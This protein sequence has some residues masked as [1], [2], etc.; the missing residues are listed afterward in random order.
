M[1]TVCQ[2]NTTISE[3]NFTYMCPSFHQQNLTFSVVDIAYYAMP[4]CCLC[5]HRQLAAEGILWLAV[6]VFMVIY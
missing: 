3:M 5:L 4:I 6:C 2:L 1:F